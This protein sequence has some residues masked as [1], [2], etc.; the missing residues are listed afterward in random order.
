M[1]GAGIFG[2][3]RVHPRVSVRVPIKCR[4]MEDSMFIGSIT[5]R[6]KM[7]IRSQSMDMSLGGIRM[8][9]DQNLEVGSVMSV[10]FSL[11]RDSSLF[12]AFAEVVWSDPEKCGVR[13]L[14]FKEQE[15]EA[16]KAA[17]AKVV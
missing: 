10:Q 4:L 13:F 3:K 1:S 7:E 9:V 5:E 12:S 8:T 15:M 6:R 11:D 16:F 14:A 17:L 2:E